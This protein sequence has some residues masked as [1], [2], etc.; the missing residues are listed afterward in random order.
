MQNATAE[1]LADLTSIEVLCAG[2][3]VGTLARPSRDGITYFEYASEWLRD[4]FSISP[5]S[6][7]LR[8][9]V[10]RT[11]GAAPD[12]LFGVF[13]DSL[14][15]DWGRYVM[16]R[17]LEAEGIGAGRLTELSRLSLVGFAGLGALEYGPR[18]T[19]GQQGFAESSSLDFDRLSRECQ[20]L[21]DDG[22]AE[23]LDSIYRYGS[24]SGGARSKVMV[25][26]DE[27]PWIVK[28]PTS[29]DG[30]DSGRAEYET[31]LLARECG[32]DIPE[33]R[34]LPS[35]SCAGF[36]A[37][38]RFDRRH[39]ADGKHVKIHMASAAALLEVSPFDVVDYRDLMRLTA[40]LTGS[41]RDT[42]QLYRVMCFNV[43][44]GNCDD[45]TRNFSYLYDEGQGTWRFSPAY[46]LTR[47]NGFLGEHS[48]LVNGRAADIGVSD[49][50]F[51]GTE[52]GVSAH[53]C[54]TIAR[55]M[56]ARVAREG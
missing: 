55:E 50:V 37:T 26:L 19:L 32:I 53:A 28:F 46:D 29:L 54:R 31:M 39:D 11:E 44:I 40:A 17:R 56:S 27:E 35:R 42:E 41:V 24:S 6:L 34:L 13:R 30:R 36:F 21:I 22:H 51:V 47:D 8:P 5:Y 48:T 49:L 9:G 10:F 52:G 43:L 25:D 38:K 45:H 2:R 33:V 12:E 4:G 16:D 7:P 20:R 15:D 23:D 1:A 3:V 14:P 18:A